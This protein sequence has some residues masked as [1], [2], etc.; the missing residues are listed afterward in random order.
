MDFLHDLLGSAL[1]RFNLKAIVELAAD[2]R[3]MPLTL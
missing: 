1:T 3:K 2:S